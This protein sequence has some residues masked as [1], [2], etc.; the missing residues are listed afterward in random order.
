MCASGFRAPLRSPQDWPSIC[1][2]TLIY[3]LIHHADVLTV[4]GESYR[5]REAEKRAGKSVESA[6][7]PLK[8]ASPS[9]MQAA[10]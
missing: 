5:L 4:E 10:P 1:A 9:D 2:T 8:S 6:K 7:R 3:R